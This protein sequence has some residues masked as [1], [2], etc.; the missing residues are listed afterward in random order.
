MT[1]FFIGLIRFFMSIS[2][3]RMMIFNRKTTK[4]YW[5]LLSLILSGLSIGESASVLVAYVVRRE[6]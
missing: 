6:R 2:L 5:F 4:F 3:I 1:P